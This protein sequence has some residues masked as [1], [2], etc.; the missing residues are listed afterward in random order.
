MGQ[1][2]PKDMASSPR[3]SSRIAA[4][5]II[6]PKIESSGRILT[7]V[8]SKKRLMKL[9][10]GA[11]SA[12][13]S[14]ARTGVLSL[15]D[16]S[17]LSMTSTKALLQMGLTSLQLLSWVIPLAN[18]RFSEN[19]RALGF[20]NAFAGGVFLMLGIGHL[21]PEVR[22]VCF[23][24]HASTNPTGLPFCPPFFF[25]R[26]TLPSRLSSLFLPPRT[27]SKKQIKEC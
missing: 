13:T 27:N 5:S 2:G 21:L 9:R 10:A 12:D 4:T 24:E 15:L 11:I 17:H 22:G 1:N 6:E 16:P 3:R 18:K 14:P 23:L 26:Q 25:A 8:S 19:Q 7:S 20:A